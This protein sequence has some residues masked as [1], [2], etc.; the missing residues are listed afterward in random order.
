M[1]IRKAKLED[2]EEIKKLSYKLMVNETKFEPSF[3]PE[4]AK[5]EHSDNYLKGKME[6]E[7]ALF[8]VAEQEG[9]LIGFLIGTV[10]PSPKAR[11][12][13]TPAVLDNIYI[14]TAHRNKGVGKGLLEGFQAWAKGKGSNKLRLGVHHKNDEAI[15]FYK[16]FG[17]SDFYLKLEKDI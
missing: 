3:Q 1:E 17:F 12:S 15:R 2:F 8:L 7:S 11:Q 10:Y 5:T 16:N 13:V 9:K 6:S 4:Y 14:D